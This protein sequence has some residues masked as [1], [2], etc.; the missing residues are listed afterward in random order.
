[1]KQLLFVILATLGAIAIIW[2][3]T[4]FIGTNPLALLV[5]LLIA[6]AYSIGIAE[7]MRFRAATGSLQHALQHIPQNLSRLDGWI[8]NVHTSLQNSVRLRIESERV[9]LPAPVLTPY[10]VGLL[11]MLGLLGT[12]IGMV[13]TLAGAVTALEGSTELQAIRAGLAAPI[14]G[15]SLA[16]GTSVAGVAAS[17]MLGLMST[18]SRRERMQATRALDAAIAT[19]LRQF[20]LTHNRQQ[21]Y[22][23]LQAQTEVLPQLIQQMQQMMEHIGSMGDTLSEKLLANQSSF[24][25]T[26]HSS[27][28]EL[29]NSVDKTLT[30]SLADSSRRTG[31]EF[32]ELLSNSMQALSNENKQTQQH[33]SNVAQQQLQQLTSQFSKTNEDVSQAWQ[34]GL[35]AQQSASQELIASFGVATNQW[36][37]RS[38]TNDEERLQ[39]W[40][41]KLGDAQRQVTE[42]LNNQSGV[43]NEELQNIASAQLTALASATQSIQTSSQ[44]LDAQWQQS[45]NTIEKLSQSI[46]EHVAD[47]GQ[48]LE[49]PLARLLETA[50][51]TPK[52]ATE[53][54]GELRAEMANNIE[55]DNVLLS[56][57][58]DLMEQLSALSDSIEIS[59]SQQQHSLTALIDSSAGVLEQVGSQFAGHVDGEMEKISTV[60][61]HFAGSAA[62]MSSLGESF[63]VAVQQ[64]SESNAQLVEQLNRVE[65]SMDA[66]GNRSDQQ[67]AYYVAQ[68]REIIDQS[69]LSQK[70]MFDELRGFTRAEPNHESVPEEMA[71]VSAKESGDHGTEVSEDL[72]TVAEQA[73]EQAAVVLN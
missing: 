60:A 44:A 42:Q 32:S 13:D 69:L 41:S 10:L 53:V 18:L 48:E 26:V 39:Q 4:L 2:V 36:L 14:N 37:E 16:F 38:K 11:V 40:Q 67:M 54:I 71:E 3:S 70:E 63:S 31:S 55:R 59:S 58:K 6:C 8:G 50:S 29:A 23:A 62:E 61:D 43:M 65:Q 46:A 30:N 20:S 7:L 21:T 1:M 51:E 27:F 9:G 73:E 22:N 24:Q 15:L 5:T 33:L 28:A 49:R 17:A 56:E 47:L 34:S 35:N 72:S 57:R 45:S 25:Q 68:A 66:S 19:D 64:Y 12:F 52:A